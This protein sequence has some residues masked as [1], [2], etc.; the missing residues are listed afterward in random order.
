[1]RSGRPLP[2]LLAAASMAVASVGV[3]VG[4]TAIVD[5]D[6]PRRRRVVVVHR[7]SGSSRAHSCEREIAR[8]LRQQARNAERQAAR[9]THGDLAFMPEGC[10]GISRRGRFMVA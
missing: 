8:R 3:R 2:L 10:T 6:K 1:M 4:G 5:E 7:S 9:V